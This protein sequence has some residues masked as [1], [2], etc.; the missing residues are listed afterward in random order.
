[1]AIGNL[2]DGRR[3]TGLATAKRGG[4]TR[5]AQLAPS[6]KQLLQS[7]SANCDAPGCAPASQT[8]SSRGNVDPLAARRPTEARSVG[9][10][11]LPEWTG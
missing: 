10:A 4:T 11:A 3:E 1:M 6:P 7:Q 8:G 9:G 5:L 2:S